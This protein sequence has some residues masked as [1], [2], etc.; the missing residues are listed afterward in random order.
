MRQSHEAMQMF[1]M[2]EECN[3]SNL[4]KRRSSTNS[5]QNNEVGKI[6]LALRGRRQKTQISILL[7]Y[8]PSSGIPN[9]SY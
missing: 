2:N 4:F 3:N 7:G 6:G 9:D 5:F 1:P 8:W